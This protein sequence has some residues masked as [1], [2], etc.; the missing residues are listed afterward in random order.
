MVGS[1]KILTVS[2][3]TFSC[4]LEGFEDSFGTMKAIAEYF[5]DLAADDRYFGA[6]PPVP[7]AEMLA[8]IAEREVAR[9]VEARM[10][11][12]GIVL[13]VGQS[14]DQTAAVG[15]SEPAEV[16]AP[17]S[18]APAAAVAAIAAAPVMLSEPVM[19]PAAT[20]ATLMPRPAMA[21]DTVAPTVAADARPSHPDPDSVAAKLDRI[22]AVVGKG[23]TGLAKPDV[24]EDPDEPLAAFVDQPDDAPTEA[25]V[26]HQLAE[27]L[28]KVA[29]ESTPSEVTTTS[30]ESFE[31]FEDM[32]PELAVD[33]PEEELAIPAEAVD[34]EAETV[35]PV[36]AD[37]VSDATEDEVAEAAAEVAPA[38]VAPLRA[39]VV[40]M[41]RVDFERSV[42]TGLLVEDGADLDT[43]DR[44]EDDA[45]DPEL[46]EPS[47]D[48]LA[49]DQAAV[50]ETELDD[51]AEI[52]AASEFAE[53]TDDLADLGDLARLD[54]LDDMP[55]A[56]EPEELDA[57]PAVLSADEEA[58][59]LAELAAVEEEAVDHAITDADDVW[60]ALPVDPVADDADVVEA[61]AEVAE[62]TQP[63]EA[64]AG[65]MDMI[66]KV[67]GQVR[68]TPEASID[69]PVAEDQDDVADAFDE[70]AEE[71]EAER[72]V[73][74]AEGTMAE[75]FDAEETID[76]DDTEEMS[77][78]AHPHLRE[79]PE[80]D[81]AAM[82]RI[83]SQ[84]DA[85]L[86][87]P[88]SRNRREAIAQ[89]KAAVAATE[90]ARRFGDATPADA[91][92]GAE[93][94]FRDDLQQVVRPRRP[95]ASSEVRS[96]RPRPAPLKLVAS[97][98]VDLPP[99]E[100]R[101]S[102]AVTMPIRPRRVTISQ[103]VTPVS[104][105]AA[106][107]TRSQATS[108]A[109]FAAEKGATS[110]ADLL[111]AAAAYTSFV[112]GVGDFSRPQILQKVSE[113]SAVPYSREDGLRSF[114]TL[115]RQG[116]IM[117]ASN[118]RFVVNEETRF[119]PMRD[120]G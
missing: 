115:L 60:A 57:T 45:S 98:R 104:A 97:Q 88:E 108:F 66:A 63:A 32:L 82:S 4:T 105:P 106:S 81:E 21:E 78:V 54:G 68:T 67:T 90:A 61:E 50:M 76:E 6:E 117:K 31:A 22:R 120:A 25:S 36:N 86:R 93:N 51:L 65:L 58:E 95:I 56:T 94:L 14:A 87:E 18:A 101:S 110:L 102:P 69:L 111:E 40:K 89:L 103:S 37:A 30:E 15:Q 118:G 72:D 64:D 8:R 85:E 74:M 91:A 17:A 43:S 26:D 75:D 12:S 114:G 27:I 96:E 1:H 29:E 73:A 19:P 3:G 109:A 71:I 70:I 7:D 9:R 23:T 28:A 38:T 33:D 39:R 116:R 119:N 100:T 20:P 92:K 46:A 24:T 55:E 107:D 2:Y 84:T 48:E 10:D 79:G 5:R 11:A 16:P 112:E 59:L 83:L 80:A 41:R 34:V 53:M 113:L 52:D 44:A 77:A 42:A 99:V 35:G 49:S 13:R 47:F 62:V